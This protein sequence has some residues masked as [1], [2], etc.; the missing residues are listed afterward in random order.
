MEDANDIARRKERS[1]ELKALG[2]NVER[3]DA[4]SGTESGPFTVLL[5]GEKSKTATKRDLAEKS[6]EDVLVKHF[7]IFRMQVRDL[8][9]GAEHIEPEELAPGLARADAIRLKQLLEAH[10]GRVRIERGGT[11]TERR[12]IPRAVRNEVWDR[13]K[14]RC[15]ECGSNEALHFDHIVPLSKGGGSNAA[16]NLQLLCERCNL[17]KGDR[18]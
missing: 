6:L 4:L 14:G 16:R 5:L 11:P 7:G 1:E 3:V 13:D 10:G 15:C 17:K 9:D 12:T 2:L 8:I 18:I